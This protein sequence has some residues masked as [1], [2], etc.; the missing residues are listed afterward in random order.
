M[1]KEAN[2]WNR[3]LE[4]K[5]I[6]NLY[7]LQVMITTKS[8][9][10]R[11]TIKYFPLLYCMKPLVWYL[12]IDVY[13]GKCSCFNN[14]QTKHAIGYMRY[15]IYVAYVRC[16]QYVHSDLVRPKVSLMLQAAFHSLPN[17]PW[18]LTCVSW[19]CYCCYLFTT[20]TIITTQQSFCVVVSLSLC[21]TWVDP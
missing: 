10:E 21:V 5:K 18:P 19:H 13:L 17:D 11:E 4:L 20:F 6:T 16:T 1:K 3:N 7:S 8:P 2:P 15:I 12:V 14:Q 9:V